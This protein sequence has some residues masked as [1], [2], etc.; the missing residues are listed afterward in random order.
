MV[1]VSVKKLL[2]AIVAGLS[3]LFWVAFAMAPAMTYAIPHVDAESSE[4]SYL[5]DASDQV[6]LKVFEWRPSRDEVYEWK[7]L[8]DTYVI[9]PNGTLSLPIVGD[10]KAAGL[11]TTGLSRAVGELMK[12]QIGLVEIPNISVEV[13][14]Y[15]PFYITGRIATPGEYAFR[16]NLTVLQAVSIAGGLYRRQAG[17]A[18]LEREAIVGKGDLD[19]LSLDR[20][21]LL[22][23]RARVQADL[24]DA[25]NIIFPSELAKGNPT[26]AKQM[27]DE[28]SILTSLRA[29]F[30][31]QLE[32]L[33]H[34]KVELE[35]E[36]DSI[37]DQLQTHQAQVALGEEELETVKSLTRRQL[38]VESRRIEVQRNV[39]QLDQDHM[40]LEQSLV[41]V[42]QDIGRT[43]LSISEVKSKRLNDLTL[44]LRDTQAKL[45]E[46]TR[47]YETTRRLLLDTAEADVADTST[48]AIAPV[49]KIVRTNTGQAVELSAD[50]NTLVQ[51]GDTIKVQLNQSSVPVA[52]TPPQTGEGKFAPTQKRQDEPEPYS[53]SPVLPDSA[54]NS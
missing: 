27:E 32:P 46:T 12:S 23:R 34:I 47:K 11:T 1:V 35:S 36:A 18:R 51:P 33:Q 21:G 37:R 44:E 20:D 3:V 7:A 19:L 14:K 10:V 38:A 9:G 52:Q 30:K 40:R 42:R 16:P 13:V 54:R 43:D 50:E 45:D 22:A 8:N 6:R 24:T 29:A 17:D 53:T 41:R 15:R 4:G 5:L 28:T 31:A 2:S 26:V 49:Y 25:S 39:Y 48:E